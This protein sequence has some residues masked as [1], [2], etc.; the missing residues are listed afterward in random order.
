MVTVTIVQLI[1]PSATIT[2]VGQQVI[3]G[4]GQQPIAF[5]VPL[6]P[7]VFDPNVKAEL[8]AKIIDGDNAWLSPSG[9]AV[10]TLGAPSQ[11]VVVRLEYRPD[12]LEGEVTGV[13]TG[14]GPDLSA[15]AVSMT[16]VLD[17]TTLAIVGYDSSAVSG[18]EP[19]PFS[20]PFNVTAIDD[21]QT[22]IASSFVYDGERSW[23]TAQGVP[24]ITL[25]NPLTDVIVTVS[26]ITAPP[27]ASPS[28]SLSPTPAPTT[29][30]STGGGGIDPLWILLIGVAIGAAVIGGVYVMRRNSA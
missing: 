22:Y 28:I 10:G 11:G 13:T 21:T 7:A 17:A 19:I 2:V 23:D 20:V 29:P 14:A 6:N 27:S 4:P 12:L 15:D 1:G 16:W 26:A 18:S 24:V 25:G 3:H 9:T 8:W 5:N 30:P